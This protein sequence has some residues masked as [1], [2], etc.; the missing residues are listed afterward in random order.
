M[1][2]YFTDEESIE[3]LM[4]EDSEYVKKTYKSYIKIG[5][6]LHLLDDENK[7]IYEDWFKEIVQENENK[8]SLEINN[9]I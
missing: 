9:D 4:N 2:D 1:F 5:E 6:K 8:E 7:T 3:E